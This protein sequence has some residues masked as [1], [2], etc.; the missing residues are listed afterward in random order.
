MIIFE[1]PIWPA[2]APYARMSEGRDNVETT[3][4]AD[5]GDAFDHGHVL[6]LLPQVGRRAVELTP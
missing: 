6:V 5:V 3:A 4:F 1:H 2:V